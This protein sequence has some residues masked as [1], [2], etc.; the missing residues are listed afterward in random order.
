MTHI[1]TT[2]T[3][4]MTGARCAETDPAA[5]ISDHQGSS[6]RAAKRVC[7]GCDIAPACLAWALAT[8]TAERAT[9][10]GVWGGKTARERRAL[11]RGAA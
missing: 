1:D 6:P 2:A 5:F 9:M 4:W 11:R 10:P 3:A 8:E 7:G